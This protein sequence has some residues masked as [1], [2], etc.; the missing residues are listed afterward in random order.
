LKTN[1]PDQALEAFVKAIAIKP[2][3]LEAKYS[4]GYAQLL[5]KNFE[6]AAAVFGDVVKQ[7]NDFPQAWMYLGVALYNL[8]NVDAAET[9][10][11]RA[12]AVK[13]DV[14]IALAHRYLGGIYL[15]RNRNAE[16]AAE[17]QKYIDM[18]PKAPDADRLKNTIAELKKKS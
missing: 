13:D 9:A 18:V 6:V 3:Y 4:V 16:A 7:K 14:D 12:V 2:D 8:K 1:D 11:K 17:L 5:K 15:Q 10:F